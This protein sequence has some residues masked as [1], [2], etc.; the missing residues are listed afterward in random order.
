MRTTLMMAASLAL[1]G[2]LGCTPARYR[3]FD[4]LGVA[5]GDPSGT[6]EAPDAWSADPGDAGMVVMGDDAWVAPG[7]D[8]AVTIPDAWVAPP[9]DA[10]T[11]TTCPTYNGDVK[12]L[13]VQHCASC[14]TTGGDPHFGSS[15]T[16]ATRTSSSCGSSMAACTIQLG[17]PGGSMARRDPYGGFDSTE[18]ATIQS[19]IDCGMPM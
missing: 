10:W 7:H 5:H 15:Y 3:G 14:H 8:A 9:D 11:G 16:V 12:P 13:Y 18:I 6:S 4:E 2:T 17:R 1:I 19:W